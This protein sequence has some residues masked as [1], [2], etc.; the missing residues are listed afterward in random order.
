MFRL[1]R[2]TARA[3]AVVALAFGVTAL[4]VAP[5][6]AQA[7][8]LVPAPPSTVAPS[9]VPSSTVPPAPPTIALVLAPYVGTFD[10][11]NNNFNVATHVL[12]QFPDLA[13]ATTKPGS[14]T[15]FLPTD[16]AFRALVRSVTGK[17]VVPERQL[18]QAV[19]RLGTAKVGAILRTHVL[20]NTRLTYGQA[21]QSNGKAFTTWQG[22]ILRVQVTTVGRRFVVL[23]DGAD[24]YADPKI[25]RANIRASNGIVHVIDRV[26]LPA[27]P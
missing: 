5:G 22:G 7:G 2:A 11:D 16:Y 17:V 15:V 18:F 9:T 27:N 23:H 26:L 3:G 24:R 1:S 8:P 20:R 4:A 19:M 21:M 6:G 14:N 13:F 12:L 25:I 10:I